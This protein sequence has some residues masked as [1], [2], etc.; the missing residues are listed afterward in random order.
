[1]LAYTDN[2]PFADSLLES[3]PSWTDTVNVPE[4]GA[5][6]DR[7]LLESLFATTT[8]LA[9]HLPDEG[10]WTRLVLVETARG[11][12]MDALAAG[13]GGA[14]APP[15]GTLCL[16]GTGS[17][18]HGQRDRPWTAAAGNLHLSAYLAPGLPAS[19]ASAGCTVLPALAAL[20]GV[21]E[22]LGEP[23]RAGIKWV[24]DI[25]VDEKK[26][27]GVL[28]RTRCQGERLTDLVIGIGLNVETCPT[29]ERDGF[30]PAVACLR[31]LAAEPARCRLSRAWRVVARS[32][33]RRY[34]DLAEGHGGKL[35]EEYRSRSVILGRRVRV[36]A[37]ARDGGGGETLAR[38]RVLEI[39][40]DLRLRLEGSAEPVT[41]GRLVLEE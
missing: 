4:T 37:D 29:V 36:V 19:E 22:L 25:L 32:L 28:T 12:Q 34:R 3:R 16:A 31:D 15:N 9:A 1:M 6:G 5:P 38:G 40:E 8:P 30:V 14:T 7:S 27:A 13:C 10:L 23:G 24:N 11:S 41:H 26:V 21:E 33:E 2:P 18:F 17:G 20:D 39:G 35:I